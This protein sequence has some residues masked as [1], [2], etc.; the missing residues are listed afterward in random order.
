MSIFNYKASFIKQEGIDAY[1]RFYPEYISF[2][3]I[4]GEFKANSKSWESV[5]IRKAEIAGRDSFYCNERP[6]SALTHKI[7][8]HFREK[9]NFQKKFSTLLETFLCSLCSLW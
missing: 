9:A 7:Q 3:N 1:Y 5:I 8:K 4:I 2:E 6:V